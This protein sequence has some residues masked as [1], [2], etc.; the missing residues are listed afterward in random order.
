MFSIVCEMVSH[1]VS[2]IISETV[3]VP[4]IGI[5]SGV[6]CDGQVLVVHDILG[7]YEKLKPKFVKQYTSIRHQA[8]QGIKAYI[9]DVQNGIF[10]SKDHS[11]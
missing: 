2:K 1:E 10:P 3:S 8:T 9:S 7:L 6:N 11:Y 4:T 5:G